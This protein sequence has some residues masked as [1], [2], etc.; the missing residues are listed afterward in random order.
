[1]SWCLLSASACAP[2]V[3]SSLSWVG[4]LLRALPNASFI[5]TTQPNCTAWLGS[6]EALFGHG[7]FWSWPSSLHSFHRCIFG[8]VHFDAARFMRRCETHDRSVLAMATALGRNVLTLPLGWPDAKKW[9]ALDSF[10]GTPSHVVASR[11]LRHG[12]A[13]PRVSTHSKRRSARARIKM[14]NKLAPL[15]TSGLTA[16]LSTPRP[17]AT[18]V[19]LGLQLGFELLSEAFNRDDGIVVRVWECSATLAGASYT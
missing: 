4:R 11:N 5:L 7:A 16:S 1:M 15:S 9:D 13:F 6:V 2:G 10:L 12:K 8:S 14:N 17:N 3:W 18:A 19:Q